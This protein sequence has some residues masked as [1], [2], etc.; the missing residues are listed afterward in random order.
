MRLHLLISSVDPLE[1]FIFNEGI[2]SICSEKFTLDREQMSNKF[3]HL[4]NY[5]VNKNHE[6][7]SGKEQRWKLSKL[8]KYLSTEHGIVDPVKVWEQTKDVALKSVLCGLEKIREESREK[9]GNKYKC[10]KLLSVDIMYDEDLKPWLLE[11]NI[12]IY[13]YIKIDF[14]I[15]GQYQL[16]TVEC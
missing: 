9:I 3:V 8:W 10:F 6:S 7:Y 1:L 12:F 14:L 13:P 5:S 16:V 2:V 4:S 15:A 11:V